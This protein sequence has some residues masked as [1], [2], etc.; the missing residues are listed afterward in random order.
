MNASPSF[1]RFNCQ[2][3]PVMLLLKLIIH[4]R[5]DSKLFHF[6]FYLLL[7]FFDQ[8][9]SNMAAR[10]YHQHQHRCRPR[11]NSVEMDS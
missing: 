9:L 6:Q 11:Q 1:K 10:S 7:E 4:C 8:I 2:A 5:I 3:I